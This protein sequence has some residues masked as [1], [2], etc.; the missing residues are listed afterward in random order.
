MC[1]VSSSL[2]PK[3]TGSED[4]YNR[5]QM[6]VNS[7]CN[8]YKVD[9]QVSDPYSYILVDDLTPVLRIRERER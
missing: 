8:R 9:I 3:T 5:T 4:D 6:I 2:V 1:V 7:S